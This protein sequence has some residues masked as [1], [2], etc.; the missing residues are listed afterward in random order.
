V[1]GPR[2]KHAHELL[3]G[4]ERPGE[5]EVGRLVG[6]NGLGEV[7]GERRVVVGI[8]P[9]PGGAAVVVVSHHP[10]QPL[11]VGGG[12]VAPAGGVHARELGRVVALL[13][14]REAKAE[15]KGLGGVGCQGE[16][17]EALWCRS[18]FLIQEAERREEEERGEGWGGRL[19]LRLSRGD[20]AG[21]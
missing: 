13:P 3:E 1:G 21:G 8:E 17:E 5:V 7:G 19:G 2:G 10:L 6:L 15:L 20:R 18:A 16:E 4:R 9:F 12:N 11:H 14:P